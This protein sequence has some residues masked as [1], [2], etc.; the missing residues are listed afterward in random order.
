MEYGY[1]NLNWGLEG[2]MDVYCKKMIVNEWRLL[3]TRYA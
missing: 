2:K 1:L 3:F